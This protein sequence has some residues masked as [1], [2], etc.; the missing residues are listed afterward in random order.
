MNI[1]AQYNPQFIESIKT[2]QQAF[3][4]AAKYA[5]QITPV[6]NTGQ[7]HW[8]VIGVHHLSGAEN[9]GNHH[10]YVDV[11]SEQGQRLNGAVLSV[12]NH[13][14]PPW[15]VVIDKPANEAGSNAPMHWND[16]LIALVNFEGLPSERVSG[17]HTRHED[18]EP[19]NTRGHHSFYVVFQKSSGL[20][21]PKPPV[22][23]PPTVVPEPPMVQPADLGER[24]WAAGQ[25]HLIPLNREAALYQAAEAH[26]LGERLSDEYELLVGEQNYIAQIFERGLVY[27]PAG[28]WDQVKVLPPR[29]G[30]AE[31]PA[32]YWD[33]HITG[34]LGNRSQ[35]YEQYLA[36][37]LPGLTWPQF[38]NEVVVHNP[39]LA[40]GGWIFRAHQVYQM[41]RA[42]G[43][44]AAPADQPLVVSSPAQPQVA[45]V[46][47]RPP[48]GPPPE[49]VQV[50]HGQFCL[51]GRPAR[52]IG[53]NIRGLV[54]YGHDPAYFPYAPKVHQIQQLQRAVEM[55]ARLV[56]VFLAHKE[57]TPAQV[58]A[59]LR[60]VLALIK[61][62][63]PSVYLLP[64]L[65]NLYSDVPF[66]VRGDEAFYNLPGGQHTILSPAFFSDG[67]R[68]NYLPFVKQIVTAFRNEPH[69]FAWEIG[70]ELKA[71]REPGLLVEFMKTVATAIKS[72]DPNHLVTTG[73]ISTRHA[74]MG[75]KPDLRRDLY[76]H[77]HLDFITIH[78]YNGNEEEVEDDS[79][80]ARAFD[81]PFI[82]EEAGFDLENDKYRGRRPEKT[83]TDLAAW[84][85]RGASCYMPWGFVA[86]D[87]DNNDGDLRVGMVGPKHA[88]FRQLYEL[89]KQCGHILGEG[90]DNLALLSERI[91][92][93]NFMPGRGLPEALPWPCPTDGF[94]F[95]V[96]APDGL[97]YYIAAG[98][99]DPAYRQSYNCWHPGEDWNGVQGG[100]TD[101]GAP[102]YAVAHGR[103]VTSKPYRTWGNIV[104]IEH[105]LP[106]GQTVW[107][108]YA[109]LKDR[110][111]Q[112]GDVVRRGTQI[113]AIG[114]G[115]R[116]QF[117]AHLHFEIRTK[118]LPANKWWGNTPADR[119]K[120]LQAYAH[121]TNF[122]TTNRPR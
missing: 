97:G 31:L 35:Y 62:N 116:D 7:P 32:V 55:N 17:I 115:D 105:R 76:G 94:D 104:L 50:K 63:F 100:N 47:L 80:L 12:L 40:S 54:H 20:V 56:R 110:L 25:P 66:Y 44:P 2:K 85:G 71:E 82:I 122:I 23:E 19:G 21:A 118:D 119:E 69:I 77:P 29:R 9:S 78:A 57:A 33:H 8:R 4:D 88:D 61:Q 91:K 49:F 107:S 72:W 3:T 90:A 96:G 53:V 112:P 59:R 93:I 26:D 64:V 74:W 16:T 103:V 109:H 11:L 114:R 48:A 38:M 101:L 89:H 73:M 70:N 75:D 36:G 92:T 45:G 120:V 6:E 18:E 98:L 111:V 41:P 60:E 34:F 28:Q 58:E 106:W 10:L 15:R 5:V 1:P 81:K 113:G 67:Y 39:A 42:E 51:K 30:L 102:V 14:Q 79:D 117:V 37:R 43:Q 22:V 68:Q 83:R 27:V 108:Q 87:F 52:F 99:V 95:P 24:L 65:T 46:M 86:T 13:N 121:P 84:F